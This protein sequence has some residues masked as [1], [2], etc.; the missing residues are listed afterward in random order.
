MVFR[1]AYKVIQCA[2]YR[3][4]LAGFHLD[5]HDRQAVV[6]VNQVVYLS[7]GAVV[8]V[9]QFVPW[10]ANSLATTVS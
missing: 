6:I 8:V 3:I 1:I 9:K 4:I 2:V 5:G 7:L 10:A